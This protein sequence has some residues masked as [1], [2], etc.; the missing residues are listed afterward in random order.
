MHLYRI[1]DDKENR[2]RCLSQ[3]FEPRTWMFSPRTSNIPT[4]SY[5]MV[6]VYGM[7]PALVSHPPRASEPTLPLPPPLL[8]TQGGRAQLFICD[9]NKVYGVSAPDEETKLVTLKEICLGPPFHRRCVLC[10]SQHH[11]HRSGGSLASPPT[12]C[13]TMPPPLISTLQLLK[14]GFL[15]PTANNVTLDDLPAFSSTTLAE[16][17]GTPAQTATLLAAIRGQLEVQRLNRFENSS[18]S[19]PT[20]LRY[21]HQYHPRHPESTVSQKRSLSCSYVRIKQIMD[22]FTLPKEG[23]CS[24][25]SDTRKSAPIAPS[26]SPP[27]MGSLG[28]FLVERN[29]SWPVRTS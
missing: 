11:N 15:S 10:L 16:A 9:L 23:V 19:S 2:V 4:L 20:R 14:S 17:L 28:L 29:F 6:K 26:A 3:A 7:T 8:P 25:N 13:S 22:I 21:Q 18:L 24:F 1:T 5:S 27:W 12:V